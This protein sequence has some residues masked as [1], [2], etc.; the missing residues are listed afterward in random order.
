[1]SPVVMSGFVR[2]VT[3]PRIFR[4]AETPELALAFCERLSAA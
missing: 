2:I 4:D 1:M 3:N